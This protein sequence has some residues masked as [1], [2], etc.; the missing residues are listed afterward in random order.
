MSRS[1]HNRRERMSAH[2]RPRE[3]DVADPERLLEVHDVA[4]TADTAGEPLLR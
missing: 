4:L 3:G 1:E 2:D